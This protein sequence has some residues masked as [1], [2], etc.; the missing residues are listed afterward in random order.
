MVAARL[1]RLP[2][3]SA[4]VQFRHDR[5]VADGCWRHYLRRGVFRMLRRL[6]SI[7]I[8]AHNGIMITVTSGRLMMMDR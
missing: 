8:Y 6:V 1:F 2:D 4:A 5:L 3:S 7:E